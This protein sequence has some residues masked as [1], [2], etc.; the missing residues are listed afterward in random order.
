MD[1]VSDV[2]DDDTGAG[3]PL[4][5]AEVDARDALRAQ[6]SALDTQ[7][8]R[9]R[10]EKLKQK[11]KS[12]ANTV[13]MGL[14]IVG[15]LV[16]G[17]LMHRWA[18]QTPRF[19]AHDIVVEGNTRTAREDIL[20]QGRIVDGVNVLAIDVKKSEQWM[21]QLPWVS[22]ARVT[23]RLP[24]TVRVVVEERT[25]AAIVSVGGG[26]YLCA[27]DGTLFKR[28]G[29]SDPTD[30]AIITGLTR[31]QF[32]RDPEL[33]KEHVRDA[34]ALLADL[35]GSSLS[36]RVRVEEVHRDA[37]GDLSMALAGEHTYVWLGQG[38]YRA[39]MSRL[40]A[41]LTELERNRLHAAEIHLESDRHPERAAVR[42]RLSNGAV[43]AGASAESG[44]EN[45]RR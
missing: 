21:Q 37:T 15:S 24:G 27:S 44:A 39:K 16:G 38:P 36:G 45:L 40:S 23:R 26:L 19:G 43:N 14:L 10:R 31:E 42:L 1:V 30:L 2:A 32:Q 5:T 17:R 6:E 4:P 34:L 12:V 22:R 29:P 7:A 28:L 35:S 20:T 41:I 9:E 11:A 13:S 25:A 18:T 8:R 3:R 33:A